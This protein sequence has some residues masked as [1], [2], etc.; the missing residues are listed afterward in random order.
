MFADVNG[1][2]IQYTSIGEGPPVVLVHGLG[3]CGGIWHGVQQVLAHH[4]H[5][6]ALDLRGHGRSG[7][8]GRFSVEGWARDVERLV[9]HLELPAVTLVG[10]SLGSL[11]VQ[12]L[13]QTTPDVCEALVLVGGISFFHPPT[14]EALR[15]RADTV[16]QHGMDAIVEDWL[17]GAIAPHTAATAPATAGLLR[18]VFLRN[19]PQMYA[20]GCRALGKAPQIRRDDIGQPTLIVVGADDRTTPLAMAEELH[21][22]I[23]VTRVRVLPRC[24]HWSPVEDPDALAAAV[25]EF[26]T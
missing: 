24:G 16:E 22:D 5:V 26:L 7:G 10:H 15:E 2:S 18:E 23:P 19:D 11:I 20:K 17:A 1:C 21:R 3:G 13:A 9:H 25:L 14:V 4:H 6:V 12:H 8:R